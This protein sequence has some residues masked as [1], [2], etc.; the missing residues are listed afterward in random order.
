MSEPS[1]PRFVH[2][3][4]DVQSDF[5]RWLP[6]EKR[7]SFPRAVR[8]FAD[9][10]RERDIPT[11]WVTYPG[12]RA[13]CQIHLPQMA[14]SQGQP[15]PLSFLESLGLLAVDPRT[16]EAILVKNR[17]SAFGHPVLEKYLKDLGIEGVI[18]TGL[19]SRA[20]VPLAVQGAEEGD[21]HFSPYVIT[22]LLA[23]YSNSSG[24]VRDREEVRDDPAWHERAVRSKLPPSTTAQFLTSRQFLE[25]LDQQ[26]ALA[27][28]PAPDSK[29]GGQ[30]FG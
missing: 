2:L 6:I 8:S 19:R 16:D 1:T 22:D 4:I 27:G 15:R 11:I 17:E 28:K 30:A 18:I 26:P 14:L 12:S 29:A 5:L 13:N 9:D 23:D 20:C 3:A 24:G 10:L 25:F 7:A 21:N